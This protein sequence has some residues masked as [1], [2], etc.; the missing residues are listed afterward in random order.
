M[1]HFVDLY[2]LKIGHMHYMGRNYQGSEVSTAPE[3]AV[4]GHPR[5]FRA[6]VPPDMHRF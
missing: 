2:T 5:L 4:F 6:C 1:Q 3:D